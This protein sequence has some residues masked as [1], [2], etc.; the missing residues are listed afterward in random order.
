MLK[1]FLTS[2]NPTLG[3]SGGIALGYKS[4]SIKMCN[5]WG[6]IGHIGLNIFSS[7]LGTNIRLVNVYG[8]FQHHEVI[9]EQL[10][11]C[12]LLQSDNI[13]FGGDLK[14]SMGFF[15]S[16]GH[17][18]QVDPLFAFFENNL[19][20][21]NVI[22]IPSAKILPTWRN[23]RV[24]E[25]SLARILDRFIIK[26]QLLCLGFINRQW[27]GSGSISDHSPIFL[28]IRGGLSK[29]RAPLKFNSTWLKDSAYTRLA[30][31]FWK[32]HPDTTSG[33]ITEGFINNL[34]EL[35]RLSKIGAHNKRELE[36]KT[37]RDIESEVAALR[38]E[39]GGVFTSSDISLLH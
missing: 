12:N 9:W 36:E 18:A 21:H 8:P 34:K 4:H 39:Q 29:P 33:N 3:Y 6:G 1:L 28:D 30:S 37:L 13:I 32:S 27:V 5:I 11:T 16:W 7:E 15:E 10:L 19:E 26:E 17:H 2:L 20:N 25:D 31:D 24:R 38:D 22:G 35:K 14:F 23:I